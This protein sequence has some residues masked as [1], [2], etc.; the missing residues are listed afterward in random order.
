MR[1]KTRGDGEAEDGSPAG[2]SGASSVRRSLRD[3]EGKER[4]GD[5]PAATSAVEVDAAL[6]SELRVFTHDGHMGGIGEGCRG[7]RAGAASNEWEEVCAVTVP[8]HA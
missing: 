3:G 2:W 1:W 5:A 7:G 4:R 6:E 8:T